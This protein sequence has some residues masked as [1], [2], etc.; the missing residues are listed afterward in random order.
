MW[1]HHTHY[2]R[3]HPITRQSTFRRAVTTGQKVFPMKE[4]LTICFFLIQIYISVKQLLNIPSAYEMN[5]L[6]FWESKEGYR[7]IGYSTTEY[8]LKH[9]NVQRFLHATDQHYDLILAEQYYQDAFLMFGHKFKAPI[10]S[11][12]KSRYSI[13]QYNTITEFFSATFGWNTYFDSMFGSFGAW[14]H[15][16]HELYIVPDRMNFWQR[17]K[18]VYFCLLDKYARHNVYIP[19]Q[20][21]LADKYFAHLPSNF[22]EFLKLQF[23]LNFVHIWL[24]GPRPTLEELGR[25]VS[26]ILQNS[27]A[28]MSSVKPNVPGIID[29]GGIHITPANPLPGKIK[30]FLDDARHGAI[31]FSFGIHLKRTL[32]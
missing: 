1:S 28:P 13:N 5:A 22:T 9:E 21:A 29:V 30:T 3:T 26:V 31:Y 17:L 8:A 19:Q 4:I 27:H 6:S 23:G 15:V 7:T 25:S 20:Q 24:A 16:P 32:N 12:C 10:V 18:N 11:I 2:L 14:A